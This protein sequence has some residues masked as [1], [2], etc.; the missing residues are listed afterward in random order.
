MSYFAPYIDSTGI[1]M[2]TY[3]D[4]LEDLCTAYRNIFGPDAELSASVPDYQLLSVFAKALDDVSALCLQAYNSRNPMYASGQALDLLLPQYGISREAGE[5]DA[6]V[7]ARIRNALAARSACSLDAL[8]ASVLSANKVKDA[9]VYINE[10]DSTDSIGIPGHS[11]A[12]VTR[13]GTASA[14]AQA[15]YDKKAPGI[16]TYGMT[17]ANAVDAEGNLH[18]VA[19]TRYA[20]KI[21]Y[22]YMFI[23]VLSG[24]DRDAISEAVIPAVVGYTDRL[25]LAVP[26]NIPQLYGVA[27][28]ANPAIADTFIIT[29]IQVAVPGA[30]SIV[31][32]TVPCDWNQ[33]I[34]AIEEGGVEIRF[35]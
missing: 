17:S 23:R 2:P 9:K 33:K 30:S 26:L 21:V 32:D 29:D 1:H 3:E 25:G 5:T 19:F 14:I 15:I 31:R 35:S 4:R 34:T 8:L 28:A 24:G 20:D 12:V 13:G 16:G 7:R 18:P 11:I 10:T 27:Y 22:I 6:S